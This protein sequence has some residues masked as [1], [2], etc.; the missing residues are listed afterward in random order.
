VWQDFLKQFIDKKTVPLMYGI[1]KYGF[2]IGLVF[3]AMLS[4]APLD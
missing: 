4:K 1:K 2:V 3:M